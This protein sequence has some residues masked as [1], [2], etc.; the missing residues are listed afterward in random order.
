MND[1]FAKWLEKMYGQHGKVATHRGKRHDYLGMVLDYS[2]QGKV[3]INMCDYVKE[4][5]ESFPVKFKPTDKA[6]TPAAEDLFGQ[7]KGESKLLDAEGV[8]NFHATVAKGLFLSKRA[9]PDIQTA[10]AFLSTKVKK[11]SED[12]WNKLIRM[13]KY[14][15]G[16][17]KMVLTL[18]A[19]DLKV[20]KWY[21][22]ASF[23]V[24]ADYKSHTGAVMTMGK[25]AVMG[26][27]RKQKLNSKSSTVAELIGADDASTMILWTKLFM[28]EQGYKIERNILYQDNKSAILLET[29]GRKSAGKQSRA[30][31]IRY[32]FLSDQVKQGNLKIE[33]CPTD[34]MQGDFMTKPL[35]GHKFK[36]FRKDILGLEN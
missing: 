25:G 24:H 9:R 29:N 6:L 18:S 13:M 1:E 15:N 10:E 4:M 34:K 12:D 32:F 19:D 27:S 5:L 28:E 21:V 31:N 26:M 36:K 7:G 14:L 3:K 17:R 16:T 30:I 33:Y 11:P 8:E 2:E 22:D 35:Q 23:A 20:I